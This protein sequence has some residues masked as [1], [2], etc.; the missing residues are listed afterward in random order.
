MI[1]TEWAP[2]KPDGWD[3]YLKHKVLTN[4]ECDPNFMNGLSP[5]ITCY[6]TQIYDK[7]VQMAYSC[8]KRIDREGYDPYDE[9]DSIEM[10]IIGLD[11]RNIKC[12]LELGEIAYSHVRQNGHLTLIKILRNLKAIKLKCE[13]KDDYHE[14]EELTKVFDGLEFDLRGYGD[15]RTLEP[16]FEKY[17]PSIDDLLIIRADYKSPKEVNEAV[18]EE[19]FTMKTIK[20]FVERIEKEKFEKREKLSEQIDK[21]MED[22]KTQDNPDYE[23]TDREDKDNERKYGV[24]TLK[25]G[26]ERIKQIK[27]INQ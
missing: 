14:Y 16:Y 4:Y 11:L 3:E 12:L 6:A 19:K 26:Y 20:K 1:I 7:L 23:G 21:G 15:A 13:H 25:R 27:N 2:W 5:E 17:K 10:E 24:I 22:R 9:K 8:S 18:V